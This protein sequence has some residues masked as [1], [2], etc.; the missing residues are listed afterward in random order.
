MTDVDTQL[1]VKQNEE[2]GYRMNEKKMYSFI[3]YNTIVLCFIS[4]VLIYL[5]RKF[6]V[7]FIV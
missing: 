7:L 4:N 6:Y 1:K 2:N 5:F 3:K